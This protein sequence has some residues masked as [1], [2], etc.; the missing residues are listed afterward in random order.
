MIRTQQ[1][2]YR[3]ENQAKAENRANLRKNVIKGIAATAFIGAAL[4]AGRHFLQQKALD[5]QLARDVTKMSEETRNKIELVKNNADSVMYEAQTNRMKV[6][7]EINRNRDN[8]QIPKQEPKQAQAPTQNQTPKPAP[9]QEPK[10]AQAPTQN[11]TP[12]PAPKQEPKVRQLTDEER[13]KVRRAN[14]TRDHKQGWDDIQKMEVEAE[15]SRRELE[16]QDILDAR[17]DN[18]RKIIDE[19]NA[20][21]ART[22]DHKQAWDKLVK[23]GALEKAQVRNGII[24]DRRTRKLI[25]KSQ[26]IF[27]RKYL[28][29]EEDLFYVIN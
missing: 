24:F 12:K 6:E 16:K 5:N 19:E 26:R 18:V 1:E 28:G 4:Y 11:Q 22:R 13:E 2:Q 29:H 25:D 21:D 10:Q 9:K 17:M 23:T 8:N 7:S 27:L 15:A 3:A 14:N 20:R